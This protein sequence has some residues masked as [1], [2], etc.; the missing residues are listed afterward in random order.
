MNY[1]GHVLDPLANLQ[2]TTGTYY[3]LASSIKQLARD[4]CGGRCV[5]FLEGGYN[6]GSLSHSVVDS[7][8]AFLG[9]PSLAKE[10]DDP[11]I[12]YE[13]PSSKVKQA[14]QR[15]KNIHSL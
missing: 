2:F 12:L 8:R 6:L 15:V 11:A 7:F 4:L 13:E 5:F 10:F 1:D 14:I 3:M 9:E